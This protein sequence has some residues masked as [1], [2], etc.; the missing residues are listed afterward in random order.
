MKQQ[1][2]HE[3]SFYI[4]FLF[5]GIGVGVGTFLFWLLGFSSSGPGRMI[6]FIVPLLMGLS[7]LFYSLRFYNVAFD[8][9][10]MYFSRFGKEQR[11]SLLSVT[12]IH[13]NVF[14]LKFFYLNSYIITIEYN[15]QDQLNKIK[16]ISKGIQRF[17]G[18]VKEIPHLIDCENL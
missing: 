10:N 6:F 14:P 15:E 4:P 12:D 7:T 16:C 11:I 1:L 8:A 3:Y 13:V 2:S 17:A 9:E 5:F 18:T